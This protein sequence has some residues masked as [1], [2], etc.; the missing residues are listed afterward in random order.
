MRTFT[1]LFAAVAAIFA[2]VS[3]VSC[4]EAIIPADKLPAAAQTFIR[5]YFPESTVS[6][7]KK[8]KEQMKT[9]YEVV[10]QDGS[11]I[12]FDSKGRW[13]KVDCKRSSVPAALVPKEIAEYVQNSFP[14]QLIV[15]IDK[16]HY[17]FEAE[18]SSGL[19]MKFGKNG[20]L[21]KIDD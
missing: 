19:E 14:G 1:K 12:D 21:L 13:D 8:D 5:E 20:K 9:T 4:R 10:L 7:V 15:K 11:E 3:I 2:S 17:G 6:Y 16:E 18:L